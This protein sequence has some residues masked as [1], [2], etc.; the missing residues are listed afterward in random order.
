MYYHILVTYLCDTKMGGGGLGSRQL[1][2][3][4]GISHLS[5][6]MCYLS[7]IKVLIWKQVKQCMT[8]LELH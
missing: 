6:T 8:Y 5:K 7:Q 4:W 3:A 2:Q 1:Q